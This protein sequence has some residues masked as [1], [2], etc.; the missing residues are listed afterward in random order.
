MQQQLSNLGSWIACA[1]VGA[2]VILTAWGYE[3][4]GRVCEIA[5]L[6]LNY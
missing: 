4:G 2:V 5:L 1:G 6:F 3:E